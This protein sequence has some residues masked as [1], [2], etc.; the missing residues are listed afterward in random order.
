MLEYRGVRFA[1]NH[2]LAAG[3]GGDGA[4]D[5][6]GA[7]DLDAVAVV[8]GT[9]R[10]RGVRIGRDEVALGIRVNANGRAKHPRVR[11]LLVEADQNAADW[12]V[13]R[14]VLC[15]EVVQPLGARALASGDIGTDRRVLNSFGIEFGNHS[16][17]SCDLL[18]KEIEY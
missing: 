5:G 11:E 16:A 9:D 2:G 7:G 1:Q 6:A 14:R 8:R 4:N 13:A 3:G 17:S 18:L 10:K 15:E 12:R